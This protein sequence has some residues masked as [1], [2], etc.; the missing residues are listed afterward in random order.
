MQNINQFQNIQCKSYPKTVQIF[1]QLFIIIS[2][3]SPLGCDF[4]FLL[5]YIYNV[6]LYVA[7]FEII[8]K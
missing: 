8:S 5:V 2:C 1:F 7:R 4:F 6:N 3:R